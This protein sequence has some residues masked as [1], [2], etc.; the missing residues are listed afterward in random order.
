MAGCA[1]QK[2]GKVQRGIIVQLALGCW[3]GH[4]ADSTL[5]L[6]Q[7]STEQS[8]TSSLCLADLEVPSDLQWL[9]WLLHEPEGCWKIPC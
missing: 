4:M 8:P 2:A 7:V 1:V 9:E 5:S 3:L 6:V